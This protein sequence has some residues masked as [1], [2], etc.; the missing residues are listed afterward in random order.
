ML[1]TFRMLL[2]PMPRINHLT[3]NWLLQHQP[4]PPPP[5]KTKRRGIILITIS[6]FTALTCLGLAQMRYFWLWENL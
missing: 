3:L 6:I 2:K 4:P 1:S 5:K